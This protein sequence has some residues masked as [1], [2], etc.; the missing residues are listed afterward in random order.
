M[1][2]AG[3]PPQARLAPILRLAAPHRGR[4]RPL[5]ISVVVPMGT[6]AM[7]TTI[8]ALAVACLSLIAALVA[9]E[10]YVGIGDL[11]TGD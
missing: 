4:L 11:D 5:A 1:H 6:Y 8:L 3:L 2:L 7:L 9:V 10:R